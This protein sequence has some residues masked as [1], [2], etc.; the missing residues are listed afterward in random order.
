ML[1]FYNCLSYLPIHKNLS[2]HPASQVFDLL[3]HERVGRFT[4]RTQRFRKERKVINERN[5]I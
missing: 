4:Q 3:D 1:L 5:N 2:A